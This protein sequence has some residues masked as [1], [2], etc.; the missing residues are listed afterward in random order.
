MKLNRWIRTCLCAMVLLALL[1]APAL[2]KV[3]SYGPDFY[4]LDDANVLSEELEGEIFFCNKLLYDACGA[5][6]VVVTVNTTGSEA[7]DDFTNDLGNK[8]KVGDA[9]KKNGFVLLLSIDD[10]DYYALPGP[11]LDSRFSAG[12]I[13]DYYDRYLETDFAAGNYESG[14]RGRHRR[15]RGLCRRE[16]HV[17]RLRRLQRHPPQRCAGQGLS[18]QRGFGAGHRLPAGACADHRAG[19]AAEQGQPGQAQGWHHA[20]AAAPAA[21]RRRRGGL[22]AHAQGV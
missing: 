15:L 4:Y 14:V 9:S 11:G 5:Q 17:E 21:H 16:R 1:C 19:R 2:A 12:T 3:P 10:E 20:P 13:K 22:P 7:I 18:R 6:I 8:W